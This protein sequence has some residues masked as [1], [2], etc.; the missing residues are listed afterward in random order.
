VPE[1]RGYSFFMVRDEI[2]IVEPSTKKIVTVISKSGNTAAAPAATTTTKT[3]KTTYTQKQREAIR[4]STRTRVTTGSSGSTTLSIGDRVPDTVELQ[5]F[6]R[7]VVRSVPTV[8]TYRYITSPRGVYVVDPA[9][10]T[11]IEEID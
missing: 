10:R 5:T 7:T 1:Y 9:R 11:I 8:K 3:T 4:K 6:D 2:V